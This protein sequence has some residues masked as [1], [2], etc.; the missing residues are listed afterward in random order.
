MEMLVGLLIWVV[1]QNHVLDGVWYPPREEAIFVG[2]SGLLKS[3]GNLLLCTE[4]EGSSG[5]Q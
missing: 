1:L 5:R 2:L 3:I 4:H